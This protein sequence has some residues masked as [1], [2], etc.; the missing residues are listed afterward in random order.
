[1]PHAKQQ[2]EAI[3]GSDDGDGIQYRPSSGTALDH[4][5]YRVM[6][7]RRC[8][9]PPPLLR[10][11]APAQRNTAALFKMPPLPQQ[12]RSVLSTAGS[13][14]L[15]LP[16][17]AFLPLHH[18]LRLLLVRCLQICRRQASARAAERYLRQLRPD[19]ETS[20]RCSCCAVFC[21]LGCRAPVTRCRA[22]CLVLRERFCGGDHVL[23]VAAHGGGG[24]GARVA[25]LRMVHRA[26]GVRQLRRR[27][28]VGRAHDGAGE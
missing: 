5:K 2:S 28:G 11:S 9:P 21:M 20:P 24:P 8:T 18:V 15:S 10:P 16:L 22:D 13:L 27:R 17:K 19:G 6:R 4:Q 12:R 26:H 1:M 7:R 3:F 14:P 25:A 23:P